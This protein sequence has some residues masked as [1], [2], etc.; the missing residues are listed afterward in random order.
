MDVY[1]GGVH[2]WVNTPNKEEH[3]FL[4]QRLGRELA[5]L[6]LTLRTWRNC[7]FL[8]GVETPVRENKSQ[9]A[10]SVSSR[11]TWR[12]GGVKA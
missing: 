4:L 1:S 12:L 6:Q 9:R 11:R 3:S 7:I 2:L 5:L 8:P 10:G